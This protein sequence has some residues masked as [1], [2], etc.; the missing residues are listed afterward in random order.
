M[1][2]WH[3]LQPVVMLYAGVFGSGLCLSMPATLTTVFLGRRPDKLGVHAA[4]VFACTHQ[5]QV[6]RLW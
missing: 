6:T 5:L 1:Q 2:V 3:D 4:E